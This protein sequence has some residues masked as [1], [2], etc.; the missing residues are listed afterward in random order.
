[1]V[2]I[3]VTCFN[4]RDTIGR[5]ITSALGQ[6]WPKIELVI[7][8]D[9]STDGSVD[10]IKALIAGDRRAK[11]I[12]HRQNGGVAAA[13]NSIVACARGE[14]VAFFDDDDESLPSRIGTQV[15]VLT[16]REKRSTARYVA[17]YAGGER[18]YPNGYRVDAPAIGMK[19]PIPRGPAV[20]EY[21]LAF[22]Q[23][24]DWFYGSGVPACALLVRRSTIKALGAFDPKQYRL[25]DVDFA[26]RLALAD[27][28]F[29]GT[30]ERL[31][32]RYMTDSFD[33]TPEAICSAHI[34]LA[35]KYRRYLESIGR[36][37]YA[38]VWPMLR[39]W[40]MKRR[41]GRFAVTLLALLLRNPIST[42]KHI[43][44][45]G[46]ARLIHERK[47]QRGG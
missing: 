18:L 38:R 41:Y 4:A 37:H 14:F 10:F 30:G 19:G 12:C 45:T 6:E 34:A 22:R 11:L 3:G 29:V 46:P 47:M 40:H 5:A 21:L 28:E 43:F 7:V 32:T 31:Y 20:A 15:V 39:Y 42:A 8:D 24:A 33:K 27:G 17:C 23:R 1:M 25:E 16:E 13:R 35:E 44:A 26:I 9:H 36:Y 2:T